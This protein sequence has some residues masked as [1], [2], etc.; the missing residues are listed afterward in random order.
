[1][2]FNLWPWSRNWCS[3]PHKTY[4]YGHEVETDVPNH[5]KYMYRLLLFLVLKSLYH[6]HNLFNY[7]IQKFSQGNIS[8]THLLTLKIFYKNPFSLNLYKIFFPLHASNKYLIQPS[9]RIQKILF[10]WIF[11]II[12]NY[13][14]HPLPSS[15]YLDP[16]MLNSTFANQHPLHLKS[17]VYG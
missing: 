9:Y 11:K 7:N 1:M 12:F 10:C 17:W 2:V 15:I 13:A 4:A 14:I 6:L 16:T 8:T 3:K 5:V